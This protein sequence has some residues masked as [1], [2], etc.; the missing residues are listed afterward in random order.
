MR[1][2][3]WLLA[4]LLAVLLLPGRATAHPFTVIT[5]DLLLDG[6]DLSLT[7][8]VSIA[9]VLVLLGSSRTA[10]DHDELVEQMP[11]LRERLIAHLALLA[12]GKPVAGAC[13]GYIPDLLRSASAPAADPLLPDR[14][15][16]LVTWTLPAGTNRLDLTVELFEKTGFTGVLQATL[17]R[18]DLAKP[19]AVPLGRPVTFWLRQAPAETPA[20]APVPL[21]PAGP[22]AGP[23][24]LPGAAPAAPAEAAATPTSGLTTW[25]L[26]AM[27]FRH[28]VPQGL[29]HIL[30][31][32]SLYLLA[33][34]LKPLLVQ[35]TAFTLAHS[36]TLGLAMLGWVLLPSRLVE[37]LIAL[38]IAVCA[39]E[40]VWW[41][42]VKPWRW[43]L[44][45]AFG[46]VHGL[47]FAGSFSQ[48]QLSPGDFLRPLLCLNLGV[49]LGQLTVVL[50]C[51]ALT[52]WLRERTWYR[53]RVTIPA[54]L[55]IA[56]VGLW[57]SVQRAFA[58]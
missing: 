35:V 36:A 44:V 49:E 1:R 23:A 32:V 24:A 19:R 15:P 2:R 6:D 57:W 55:A 7:L 46:L 53:Q 25:D 14:L 33:P 21:P 47:G 34:R 9:D 11:E 31:V 43:L 48:L 13:H 42:E 10:L 52:W 28:I 12:D 29:D 39:L 4:A 56:A 20:E 51:V 38:S 3:W 22:V 18:G 5:G 45:F 40:N 41:K 58:L 54:S 17:H 27:G 16:F 8:Q 26:L 30:F 50:A 37:T